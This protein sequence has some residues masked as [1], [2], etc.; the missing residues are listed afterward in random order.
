MNILHRVFLF[1][2]LFTTFTCHAGEKEDLSYEILK[3]IIKLMRTGELYKGSMPIYNKYRSKQGK[4]PLT[5]KDLKPLFDKTAE[6]SEKAYL[7]YFSK[8]FSL[9]ELQFLKELYSTDVGKTI[10]SSI[11]KALIT[12]HAEKMNFDQFSNKQKLI[13]NKI[14]LK[15]ISLVNGSAQRI[16]DVNKSVQKHVAE[17]FK[18]Y[19]E[20]M[21]IINK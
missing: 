20:L 11:T 10:F 1:L 2:L 12:G 15:N 3:P 4:S 13:F 18:K 17:E 19:P 5:Y 8:E 14:G 7:Q 6:L 21:S 16:K 9:E